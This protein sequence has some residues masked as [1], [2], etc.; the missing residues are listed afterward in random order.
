MENKSYEATF[1]GLNH[2]D[3]L[4]QTLPSYGLLLRQ[5]YGTGHFSLD[6]YISAV[7]GQA[8]APDNQNDCPTYKDAAPASSAADGQLRVVTGCVYPATVPTLFNQLDDAHVSWKIYAQDMGADPRTGRSVPVR[9]SRR[10][11][12]LRCV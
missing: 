5:Y 11:H 3:Y 9:H 10:S 12:G 2:N 6:N 8:P 7:A 4:W 1:S